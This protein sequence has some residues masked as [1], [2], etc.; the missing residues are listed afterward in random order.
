MKNLINNWLS[1]LSY[2]L[3]D[4]LISFYTFF[5]IIFA[6]CVYLRIFYTASIV[7][8]FTIILLGYIVNVIVCALFKDAFERT[9]IGVVFTIVYLV[10]F[11]TLFIIGCFINVKIAIITTV[12]PLIITA[13]AINIRECYGTT[14]L[15]QLIVVGGPV[16]VFTISIL[17]LSTLP[18]IL[19]IIIPVLY[20]ICAPFIS[21]I[22][23]EIAALNIFE[24]AFDITWSRA[25]EKLRKKF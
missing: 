7:V 22:E 24:L 23:D 4:D 20:V 5:T 25:L 6:E 2:L 12:I 18:S 17:M 19:K 8:P 3:S 15:A 13:I 16:I 10:V 11:A 1:G 21:Y 9:R 14:G